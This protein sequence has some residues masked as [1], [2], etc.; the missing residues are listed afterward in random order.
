MQRLI[1]TGANGAGK[2]HIARR[3]NDLRPE[4]PLISFDAIKLTSGWKQ[5]PRPEIEAE[6]SDIIAT[7]A[8][9]LEGG[10]SLLHQ[11]LPRAQAVIWLDP[12]ELVRAWRL[13]SRPWR[14]LGKT[15]PELPPGNV[16]WP[17]QQYRFAFRSIKKRTKFR[18]Y[19][20]TTL[21]AAED[22]TVW[23]CRSQRQIDD[24]VD[25]WRGAGT[26]SVSGNT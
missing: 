4:I 9:I 5:R 15:R 1:V 17:L 16:D 12:S 26:Q 13:V 20:A 19:I 22:K 6:L 10:P 11:A 21:D 7:D 23:H 18:D 24:V 25:H 2:S 3:L 14:N 8:W